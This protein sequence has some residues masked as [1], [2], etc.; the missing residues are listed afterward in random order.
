MAVYTKNIAVIRGVKSGFSQGQGEL[1]G[2]VKA[3]KY[4]GF[5]RAEISLINFAPLSA[6]RYV[7]GI[8]DG[9]YAE[10]FEGCG[11]ECTSKIDTSRGFAAAVCYAGEEVLPVAVAFCGDMAWAV[12]LAVR[13]VENYEKP[14]KEQYRDEAIAEDNYYEYGKDTQ[15]K[16]DVSPR[17]GQKEGHI[18]REN[19]NS[20]GV[21]DQSE[22][23]GKECGERL[24]GED[25]DRED[26]ENEVKKT[27]EKVAAAA[28][29]DGE[30]INSPAHMPQPT[31]K[32]QKNGEEMPSF[33][34]RMRGEI[35]KLFSSFPREQS[36]EKAVEGSRWVRITY[37]GKRFYVFGVICEDGV[38]SCICY[39]VPAKGSPCPDSLK[40]LAGYIP[41]GDGYWVMYQ[42]AAT[43]ASIKIE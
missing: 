43:G 25:G 4:G 26:I 38:P 27:A 16:G 1:S 11:G 23:A 36:L 42:S 41:A 18:C 3:E 37:G 35:E 20:V 9:E 8:S 7:T 19:E 28:E 30:K 10:V 34:A 6:G 5:F 31:K 33:Y 39:G 21:C 14:K 22:N 2:V 24:G 32:E 13:A 40:G 17:D 12:P 15:S 29:N